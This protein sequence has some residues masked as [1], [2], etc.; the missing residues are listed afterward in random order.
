M[1][2]CET[3]MGSLALRLP[4]GVIFFGHGAQKM[5]GWFGGYGWHGTMQYFTNSLHI[6][7]PLQRSQS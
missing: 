2:L 5:L 1:A 7:R 3:A 6:R 4:L